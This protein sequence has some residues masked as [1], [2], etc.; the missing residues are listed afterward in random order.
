MKKENDLRKKVNFGY[1]NENSLMI[2]IVRLGIIAILLVGIEELL[3]RYVIL[4]I[5]NLILHLWCFITLV[6][7]IAIYLKK[8]SV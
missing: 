3:I 6:G 7:M 8:I 5:E 4:S 1:V 2:K